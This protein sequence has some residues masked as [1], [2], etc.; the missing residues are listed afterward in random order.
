[1]GAERGESGAEGDF[2]GIKNACSVTGAGG[3]AAPG[4]KEK[5]GSAGDR[6]FLSPPSVAMTSAGSLD[7]IADRGRLP[8]AREKE[9]GAEYEDGRAGKTKGG[10][11]GGKVDL[12]DICG[13]ARDESCDGIWSTVK[14][15]VVSRPKPST[16]VSIIISGPAVAAISPSRAA[17][18]EGMGNSVS[19]GKHGLSG[20]CC[21]TSC[22]NRF[23]ISKGRGSRD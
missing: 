6:D 3:R 12:G 16:E 11:G 17:A 4:L 14:S 10:F 21:R 15:R 2:G 5:A 18:P 1:M 20:I 8:V 22:L 13:L 7:S 23:G 19:G 9:E